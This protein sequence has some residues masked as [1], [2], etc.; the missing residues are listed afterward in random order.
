MKMLEKLK[1]ENKRLKAKTRKLKLT[2]PQVKMTTPHSKIKSPI[3]G[4]KEE[5]RMISLFI[6][7]CLSIT[8][9][10]QILPLTLSYPLKRH[11]ILMGRTIT[12]RSI[13]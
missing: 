4:G 13:A 1:A 6:T 2:P 8:I 12:N 7:L 3:K 5:T 9:I 11:P 10:C